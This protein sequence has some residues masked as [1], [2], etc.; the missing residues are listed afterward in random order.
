MDSKTIS[1]S[2]SI[3]INPVD[4]SEKALDQRIA[5]MKREAEAWRHLNRRE[6]RKRLSAAKKKPG[7][8]TKKW[9]LGRLKRKKVKR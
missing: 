3:T 6:R 7:I 1:D 4:P 5:Q 8:F 9:T 2:S